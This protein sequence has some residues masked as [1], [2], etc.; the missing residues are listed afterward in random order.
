MAIFFPESFLI[1]QYAG[2][3]GSSPNFAFNIKRIKANYLTLSW[4][5]PISYINQSIDLRSKSMGWFLYDIGL[6]HERVNFHSADF[7]MIWREIEASKVWPPL[8]LHHHHPEIKNGLENLDVNL[9]VIYF[10]FFF[11]LF[12]FHK[13]LMKFLYLPNNRDKNKIFD[14]C[15]K[16]KL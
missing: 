10:N 9:D 7:L 16:I 5:R 12:I 15:I 14:S 6:R 8:S 3:E 4:R 13:D 11:L 1:E 2:I